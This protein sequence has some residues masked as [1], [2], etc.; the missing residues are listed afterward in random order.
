MRKGGAGTADCIWLEEERAGDQRGKG[1]WRYER[2]L[3]IPFLILTWAKGTRCS[4][5]EPLGPL[6]AARI[7]SPA[8][9]LAGSDGRG[10]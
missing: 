10:S 5:Q 6:K 8:N 2:E 9:E 3:F 1:N 7:C 4:L